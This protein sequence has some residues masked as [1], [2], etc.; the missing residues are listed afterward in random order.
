MP[1][2]VRGYHRPA[3]LAPALVELDACDDPARELTDPL[4][5]CYSAPPRHGKSHTVLLFMVRYLLRHPERTVAYVSYGQE[6]SRK[7]SRNALAFARRAGLELRYANTTRW[8]TPQLGGAIFTSIEGGFTGEGAHV[9]VVDDPHK[10]RQEAESELKREHVWEWYNGVAR[11]RLEPGAGIIITHTRWVADDLMGRLLKEQGLRQQGGRWQ[12]INLKAITEQPDG[13]E[14]ALWPER[15]P[16]DNPGFREQRLD[17]PY[18]W[19]SKYQGEPRPKGG[20]LFDA[21]RFYD[22]LPRSGY[23]LGIGVD[24]ATTKKT[25]ADFS[26]AVVLLMKD[27]VY[28]VIDVRRTQANVSAVLA[29]LRELTA[30]YR[31]VEMLWHTGGQERGIAELMALFTDVP[32]GHAPATTDKYTR[33]QPVAAAWR[34]GRV[35][36]PSSKRALLRSGPP[37]HLDKTLDEPP[38]WVAPFTSEVMAF[39]GVADRYDDQVD[40]L[41]SAHALLQVGGPVKGSGLVGTAPTGDDRRLYND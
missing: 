21:V 9:L 28:Y 24:L 33:A 35:L 32:L 19:A 18:E 26:A 37:R 13:T 27:D 22:E 31:G 41:G 17:N 30:T 8:T 20:N 38:E 40:A 16:V 12:H 3:H 11:D 5:L 29:V 2:V 39:T 10:N 7:Q 36:L 1:R 6:L 25:Y 34:A 15:W 4:R 23:R 14:L